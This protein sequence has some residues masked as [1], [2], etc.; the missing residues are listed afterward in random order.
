MADGTQPASRPAL[1]VVR[2]EPTAE[3][4][5]VVTALVTAAASTGGAAPEHVQRG[6]WAD[7]AWGMRIPLPAGAGA[8]RNSLR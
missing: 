8:W 1:R 7:P 3:E 4:L 5:A 6:R 2:G